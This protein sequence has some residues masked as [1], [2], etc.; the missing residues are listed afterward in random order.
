[1]VSGSGSDSTRDLYSF[2][3]DPIRISQDSLYFSSVD[4]RQ[5]LDLVH[6]LLIIG[7]INKQILKWLKTDL[8]L[9]VLIP[10]KRLLEV[11]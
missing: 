6:F 8:Y 11:G 3:A 5:Q 2:K 7:F 1:M 10:G 4:V 9:L